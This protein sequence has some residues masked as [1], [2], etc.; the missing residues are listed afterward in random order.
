MPDGGYALRGELPEQTVGINV[1]LEAWFFPP[2]QFVFGNVTTQWK[3][4]ALIER[5]QGLMSQL[6]ICA[7]DRWQFEVVWQDHRLGIAGKQPQV[8][9][10]V[11]SGEVVCKDDKSEV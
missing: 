4:V 2:F 5:R 7:R 10:A 11:N 3:G 9:I 8:C 1:Q 6:S